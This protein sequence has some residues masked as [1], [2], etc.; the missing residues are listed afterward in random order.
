VTPIECLEAFERVVDA[1]RNREHP[2]AADAAWFVARWDELLNGD[3]RM[4][5]HF[6][7]EVARQ[8]ARDPREDRRVKAAIERRAEAN[9]RAIALIDA[10]TLS[11][12]IELLRAKTAAYFASAAWAADARR[13]QNPHKNALKA[14][15][16][17][18]LKARPT[19]SSA[20]TIWRDLGGA[21]ERFFTTS[22]FE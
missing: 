3:Q 2:A 18:A 5:V 13:E 4:G 12:R 19:P 14:A 1:I 10:P 7:T 6:G 21:G 9:R 20:P 16:W 8:G 17:D 15:I 11:A 22:R